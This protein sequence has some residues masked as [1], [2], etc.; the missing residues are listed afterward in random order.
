MRLPGKHWAVVLALGLVAIAIVVSAIHLRASCGSPA[1]TPVAGGATLA[2]DPLR[3]E[4]LRCQTLGQAG[5]SDVRCLRAWSESRR[6][7]L[8]PSAPAGGTPLVRLFPSLARP[9]TEGAAP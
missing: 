9:R 3:L 6:R 1:R 7:F 5:A 8:A 4:L 2:I